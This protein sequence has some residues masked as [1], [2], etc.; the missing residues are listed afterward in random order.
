LNNLSKNQWDQ[1]SK[2][3][4][5]DQIELLKILNY[6]FKKIKFLNPTKTI[7]ETSKGMNQ[8]KNKETWK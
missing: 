3:Q 1:K 5:M 6:Q 2:D 8:L 4:N 7:Q